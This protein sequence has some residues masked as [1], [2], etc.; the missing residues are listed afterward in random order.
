MKLIWNDQLS[1]GISAIDDQHRELIERINDLTSIILKGENKEKILE[2]INFL[3]NYVTNH[4]ANE[5]ALMLKADYPD[6]VSHIRE[7]ATFITRLDTFKKHFEANG[8]SPELSFDTQKWLY[9][10]LISH[11]S[12]KDKA[13]GLFITSRAEAG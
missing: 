8:H 3:D 2:F 5:E 11:I 4:F 10:W 12:K 1:V 13:A 7:H 6:I 9:G